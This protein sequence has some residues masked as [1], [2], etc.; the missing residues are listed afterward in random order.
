M[1]NANLG[2]FNF[3][4][5]LLLPPLFQLSFVN[6]FNFSALRYFKNLSKDKAKRL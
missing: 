5:I 3:A 6:C 2:G 1:P 4:S